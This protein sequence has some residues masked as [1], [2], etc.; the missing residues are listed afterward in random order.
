M[1][2]LAILTGNK[3]KMF[4]RVFCTIASQGGG[5]GG[6]GNGLHGEAPS[7]RRTFHASGI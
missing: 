7:E 2:C 5:G 6:V 3:K 4:K 1:Q